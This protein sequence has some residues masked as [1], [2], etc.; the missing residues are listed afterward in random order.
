MTPEHPEE[1]WESWAGRVASELASLAEGGFATYV[2]RPVDYPDHVGEPRARKGWRRRR[3]L[4]TPP[5]SGSTPAS[6]VLLQASVIEGLLALECIGDTE[7]EGFSDLSAGQQSQL[8]ALGWERHGLDPTFS[9]T[10]SRGESGSAA[11]L[12]ARSLR[13]VL[14]ADQPSQVETR[15]A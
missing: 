3:P 1:S 6:E 10:Y 2:V 5:P 15:H 13:E 14:E 4:R 7:F 12:L 8:V 11:D 9:K